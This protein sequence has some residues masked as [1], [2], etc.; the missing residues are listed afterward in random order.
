[1]ACWMNRIEF[2][3]L[4]SV[5]VPNSSPDG[6]YVHIGAQRALF[7]IAVTGAQIAQDRPQLLHIGGGLGGRAHIGLG[8]DFHQRDA[9]AVQV[10]IA[11]RRMLV[12]HRL[13]GILLEM[14]PFDTD[15]ARGAVRQPRTQ[16]PLADDRLLVLAD[17]IALR[18]VGIEIVLAVK[19]AEQIDLGIQAKTGADRLTDHSD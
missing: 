9:G 16:R 7:H 5:R 14:Q 18:Q 2:R 19:H 15:L 8:D 3:F 4:V 6:R 17:L 1:M 12:M 10:D 13:A 11:L